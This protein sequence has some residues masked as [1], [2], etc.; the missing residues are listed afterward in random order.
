MINKL[1]GVIF[2]FTPRLIQ[3]SLMSKWNDLSRNNTFIKKL[4]ISDW[5]NNGKPCPPPHII[6]QLAIVKFQEQSKYT[7]LIE[8]GTFLGDMIE[9]Q[10]DR[11]EQ[12]YSIE[13][14]KSL[15][16]KAQSR[17][18]H[19]NRVKILN[20][21]SGAVLV[22][23]MKDV[24]TPS[25]FWLDGHYSGGFTAKGEKDCPILEELDAIFSGSN[26]QHIIL[27]DDARL[28]I[29]ENAYPTIQELRDYLSVKALNYKLEIE[30]DII[31]LTP[32]SL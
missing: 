9:A 1:M 12:L 30:D 25:I 24:N 21:D 16:L 18:E 17:F 11:F 6:K 13:L 27:I 32:I 14:S 8:T 28:F 29:G 23:L 19:L 10:K 31:A 26:F 4:I 5:A 3:P 7:C 2:K 20:G 22:S 15:C